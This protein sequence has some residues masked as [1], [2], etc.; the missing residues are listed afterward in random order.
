MSLIDDRHGPVRNGG[1][2]RLNEMAE[3][4]GP[5]EPVDVENTE[6]EDEAVD[7]AKDD[8]R[9]RRRAGREK[10][11]HRVRGPQEAVHRPRLTP[12]LR[13]EPAGQDRDEWQW[14]AEECQ[15]EQEA[16]LVEASL[17]AE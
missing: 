6:R 7:R 3:R 10:R 11:R 13:R 1:G 15:P 17:D 2:R 4:A 8:E 16:V 9:D 12:D 5:Q 14:K